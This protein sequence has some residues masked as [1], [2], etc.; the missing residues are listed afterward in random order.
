MVEEFIASFDGERRE[1]SPDLLLD[2]LRIL[3]RN[4][5]SCLF[6]H[7]ISIFPRTDI[8]QSCPLG[9]VESARIR[10]HNPVQRRSEPEHKTE[11]ALILDR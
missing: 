10:K 4:T 7:R 6:K 1:V 11:T 8:L 3:I 9:R 5:E 2:H